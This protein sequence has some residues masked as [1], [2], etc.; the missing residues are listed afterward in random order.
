M[1]QF[2]FVDL[3]INEHDMI[4]MMMNDVGVLYSHVVETL[5]I[6]TR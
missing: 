4:M 6:A 3:S 1:F 2:R 5:H